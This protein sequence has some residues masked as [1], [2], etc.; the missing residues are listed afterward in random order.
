MD[1]DIELWL[2]IFK[3]LWQRTSRRHKVILFDDIVLDMIR[4]D[5]IYLLLSPELLKTYESDKIF[6]PFN[7]AEP[8]IL[9]NIFF[10]TPSDLCEEKTKKAIAL[11]RSGSSKDDTFRCAIAIAAQKHLDYPKVEHLLKK[12]ISW[13]DVLNFVANKYCGMTVSKYVEKK[14]HEVEFDENENKSCSCVFCC[15][16]AFLNPLTWLGGGKK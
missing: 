3:F 15:L 13:F 1:K 9:A 4:D 10:L 6:T 12:P 14:L 5:K 2:K 11:V 16:R 8:L 7:F